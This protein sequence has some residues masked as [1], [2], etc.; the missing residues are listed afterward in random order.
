MTL[1]RNLD[2]SGAECGADM[3]AA[4]KVVDGP[5]AVLYEFVRHACVGFTFFEVASPERQEH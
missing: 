1:E 3:I 4:V 2:C 5:R